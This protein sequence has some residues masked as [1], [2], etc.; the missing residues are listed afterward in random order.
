MSTTQHHNLQSISSIV[1]KHLDSN[2][3][4][5]HSLQRNERS[6]KDVAKELVE[7]LRQ[8][9][10]KEEPYQI[11]IVKEEWPREGAVAVAI[12]RYLKDIRQNKVRGFRTSEIVRIISEGSTEIE[13]GISCIHID[14]NGCD[15][16]LL[17]GDIFKA[18]ENH[19]ILYASIAP[20][21]IVIYSRKREND[22]ME[23]LLEKHLC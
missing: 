10:S 7:I 22:S 16:N 18:V 11:A 8:Q 21:G 23:L 12:T 5:V 2:P 4:L 1:R 15:I 19:S 6:Q 20:T 17:L 9:Y 14:P 13:D 3:S